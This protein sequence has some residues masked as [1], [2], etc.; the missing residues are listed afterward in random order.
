M[1]FTNLFEARHYGSSKY[2]D[3]TK[4]SLYEIKQR[5]SAVYAKNFER[6]DDACRWIETQT[7]PR[8]G[9][10][11]FFIESLNLDPSEVDKAVEDLTK[12]YGQPHLDSL[13]EKVYTWSQRDNFTIQIFE[14]PGEDPRQPGSRPFIIVFHD[15]GMALDDII[16]KR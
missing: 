12:E 6:V 14:Y 4:K 8:L 16:I 9:C 13:F 7:D 11:E 3:F 5:V 2:V 10:E 15:Y 1:R